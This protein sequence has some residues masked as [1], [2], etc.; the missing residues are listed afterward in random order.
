MTFAC[1]RLLLAAI[2]C[3]GACKAKQTGD[4]SPP[5]NAP[6]WEAR[7]AVAFDDAYT[8][9]SIALSGRAPNDVLDQRLF[10]ARL[11]HSAL[12]ALVT[13]EQVWGKGRY[14]GRQTQYLEVTLREALLGELPRKASKDQLLWVRSQD[15]L[16]GSLQGRDMVLF[17]RWAPGENPSYHH[18]LMPADKETL[19]WIKAMVE[20][21]REEGVV[22]AKG[23]ESR[24]S[25][26]RRA[27]GKSTRK[28]EKKKKEDKKAEKAAQGRG[29]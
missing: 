11:G 28:Q 29:G 14:Q 21:A 4:L 7:F 18:H 22:D 3:A 23:G 20:H 25:Q 19:T 10:A 16:P 2:L 15:E 27:K 8:R 17:L 26:R 24:R 9:E 5:A 1:R 13:V 6:A 12:V